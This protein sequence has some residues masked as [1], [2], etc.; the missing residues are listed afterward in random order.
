MT[1]TEMKLTPLLTDHAIVQRHQSIPVWG[2]TEKPHTRIKAS[3]GPV[4]A[5]GISGDDARF[6]LRLPALPAGGPHTLVV[7]TMDGSERLEVADILVGDVWFASGQSNMEWT[8]AA[9]AYQAEIAEARPE[10]IRMFKVANRAD[11]APQSTVHGAWALATPETIGAFS[12]VANFFAQRLQDELGIPVGVIN[13]TWG[14]SFIETWISRERLL[15]NP[16]TRDL[17]QQYEQHAY[18]PA[19]WEACAL[20]KIFPSDPGNDGVRQGWHQNDF[21]DNHW[22]AFAVPD[23][24]Q[25]QGHNYSAVMWFR[26]RVALPEALRGQELTLH[27]GAV[28]K[29]D[30][31]YVNDVEVGRT[32]TG[33]DESFWNQPRHYRVP[34]E[35]TRQPEL[36][37]A[38][39]V[40]SFRYGGGLIGP[41]AEM[42]LEPSATSAGAG[43]PLAGEWRCQVEHNFG[44][45]DVA[46]PSMGHGNMNSFYMLFE[47]MVRPLLPVGIAGA[48]WYQGESNAG[49]ASEYASLLRDLIADWRF[50]FGCGEFPFGIVQLTAWT[51]ARDFQSASTWARLR[52]AQQ[53]ALEVPGTGLAVILDAGDAEDI[54]PK[55][56][57]TV[58]LR[59]AQWALARV[60]G[61]AGSPGGPLYCGHRIEGGR[62]RVL[63][64]QAE[65]GLRL[66]DGDAVRTLMI[67]G[68]NGEFVP[69]RSA[70]EGAS[71]VVWHDE[72]PEPMAVRY[73]WADN[74]AG[75]N[76]V[77][78]SGYPAGP[79]RT[80]GVKEGV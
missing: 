7:E 6:L 44:L 73:A 70:I 33:F 72:I 10:Q 30:I 24:W 13:S 32:G 29:Q 26:R 78:A 79:F 36:L 49:K 57:K 3:L 59:L 71:L 43:L 21:A 46:V 63:F 64:E 68:R 14:G 31:T 25:N 1:R 40:Y 60:Y 28:D 65:N 11:L 53:D 47:N 12:A 48:I 55:D 34:A 17:V 22:P 52:E 76:L 54:H 16:A 38:V 4:Q 35:L 41:A 27:L 15:R 23:I 45:V 37:I 2:W 56:K 39:R 5:E 51:G 18:S 75:A 80:D 8:M 42:R 20:E 66:R 50:H 61:R 74:P 77:D 67:A 58:G 19:G 9:S 69:A 62:I